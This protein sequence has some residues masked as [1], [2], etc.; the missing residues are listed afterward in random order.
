[1]SVG[2]NNPAVAGG[3]TMD[4]L[5]EMIDPSPVPAG[6][7]AAAYSLCLAMSLIYKTLLLEINREDSPET[8]MNL[9]GARKDIERLFNDAQRLVKDDPETYTK[10][11]RSLRGDDKAEMTQCFSDMIAVS[12]NLVEK[13]GLALE[14][15]R[16]LHAIVPDQMYTHLRVACELVMGAVNSAIH[17]TR[18]NVQTIK[19]QKKKERYLSRLDELG[20]EYQ[21]KYN[22][23][24]EEIRI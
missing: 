18:D 8:E 12:M 13:S 19:S 10:F 7:A 17:L 23:V 1:M 5:K 15:I 11:A 20:Q 21:Q 3:E 2:F 16:Q 14:W 22:A 24:I 4:L 9:R 6:G